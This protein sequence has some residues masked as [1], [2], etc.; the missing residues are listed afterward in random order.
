MKKILRN[1]KYFAGI[2]KR[3]SQI[4]LI[5]LLKEWRLYYLRFSR[6][7]SK[8][9]KKSTLRYKLFVIHNY[10]RI[11]YYSPDISNDK[12]VK[13]VPKYF[14]K[15]ILSEITNPPNKKD[16]LVNKIRFYQILDKNQ[17]PHPRVFFYSYKGVYYNLNDTRM[18]NIENYFQKK[19]FVKSLAG[20]SGAGADIIL[21]NEEFLKRNKENLVFQEFV[22]P[23][24]SLK[25][26]APVKATPTL[27]INSYLDK[28]DNLEICSSFIKWP[29]EGSVS[30]NM[31]NGSIGVGINI[32]NGILLAE[33]MTVKGS[34]NKNGE[35]I[36][37]HPVSNKKF[38]NFSIPY[39]KDII[40]LLKILHKTFYNL[41]FIGWDIAI[42]D[43][44]P[45]IIEGNSV[46]DVFWEQL[47]SDTYFD[48]KYIQ[49]NLKNK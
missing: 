27:R 32:N 21:F 38:E 18:H 25:K 17:I 43:N 31:D 15:N 4:G 2:P 12:L 41:K 29:I 6:L 33:G 13:I 45:V 7:P 48:K 19:M 9:N 1:S 34:V 24:K 23:E 26:I 49:E 16:E 14:A 11:I 46:G 37:A 44:G 36:L 42:T 40:Y 39:W 5:K 20:S 10:L 47:I 22:E 35:K 30:D 28:F 3:V 8:I